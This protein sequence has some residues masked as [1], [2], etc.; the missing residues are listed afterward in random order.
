MD[1][2]GD[3]DANI[4]EVAGKESQRLDFGGNGKPLMKET[5]DEN[6]NWNESAVKK[7]TKP[8]RNLLQTDDATFTAQ[9][10]HKIEEKAHINRY[11]FT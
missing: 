5:E 3:D 10:H 1:I 9:K 4:I 6:P 11:G 8:I 7:E 2:A